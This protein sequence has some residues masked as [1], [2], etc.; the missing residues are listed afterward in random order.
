LG[1]ASRGKAPGVDGLPYEFYSKFGALVVPLL[2]AA[3]NEAFA[4]VDSPSALAPL[5]LGLIILIHKGAGRPADHLS[6][7]RPITLLNC[8]VK[9][10]CKVVANRLHLPLDFLVDAAQCA[11]IAGRDSSA[12]ILFHQGMAEH[13]QRLG[14]PLWLVLSD[15]A[16]A[17]DCVDWEFLSA[18]MRGMGFQEVGHVRWAQLLHQGGRAMVFFFFFFFS[19]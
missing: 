18:T 6:G 4:A 8:D 17:Y 9:L 10:L 16:S 19:G 12:S 1:Q 7:Q 5:L 14:H 15:L 13:L 2:L 11:F 3:L